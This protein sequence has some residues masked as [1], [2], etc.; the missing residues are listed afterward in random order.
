M[1]EEAEGRVAALEAALAG[2]RR[3]PVRVASLASSVEQYL[4]DLRGT[5]GR[6]TDLA[7]R[8]L[9]RGLDRIVLRRDGA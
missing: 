5:V 8:L 9:V 4:R 1:L 3:Q 2:P 7:R 6:N